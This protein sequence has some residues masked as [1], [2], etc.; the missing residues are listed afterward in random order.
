MKMK[1]QNWQESS[2]KHCT[3]NEKQTSDVAGVFH[4]GRHYQSNDSLKEN[5]DTT[6]PENKAHKN[7]QYKMLYITPHVIIKK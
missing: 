5:E 2:Y 3:G 7:T 1:Y 6:S 4:D